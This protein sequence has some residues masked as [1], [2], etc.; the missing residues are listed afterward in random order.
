MMHAR[1]EMKILL[2]VVCLLLAP[3][4]LQA[5]T[6]AITGGT[7]HPISGDPFVGTVVVSDGLITAAG[8]D[9]QAPAD[10]RIIDATG[11]H[12]YP[13]M[14]DAMSQLGLLEIGAVSA[15]DDQAELGLFNPHL[16]AATAIHPSSELIPV[17]RANGITHTL[18]APQVDDGIIAGQAAL[19]Q[20]DGW[21][22]EEMALDPAIAMVVR[23]PEIETRRFDFATFS[24][25]ET[26]YNEAKEKAEEKRKEVRQWL[27]AAQHYS[28]AKAAGSTR[29]ETD[30]K[31]ETLAQWVADDKLVIVRADSKADIESAIEY[32]EKIGFRMILA[33]GRD[34]WRVKEQLAE[35][36]IPVILGIIQSLPF[37]DDEPYDMPARNPVELVEAGVKIAFASGAGGGYGPGGPHNSRTTPYEAATAVAYGLS[38]EDAMKALTLWPAE[39]LGFGDHLGSIEAGKIANLIVT[40][41]SPLEITTQVEHLIINGREVSTDNMH[42]RLYEKYRSRPMPATP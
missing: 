5:E 7:V 38:E 3:I 30:L 12:V 11:K 25:K 35:K 26:P 41:G 29:L 15:T 17:A 21:T 1:F 28:Q 14:I 2:V 40:D 23:W 9:A 32:S 31:L 42:R 10:A 18:V 39:F 34:A 6:L 4:V 33:G 27:E 19:I 16:Q 13:G 36:Q 22:V 24:M 37:E 20:L 8:P